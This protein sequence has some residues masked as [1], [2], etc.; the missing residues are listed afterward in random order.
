MTR[1]SSI[2]VGIAVLILQGCA[3]YMY[4]GELSAEDSDGNPRKVVIYWPMTDPLIGKRKAGPV[5]VLTECGIPIQFDQ[6]PEGVVFRGNPQ[7]DR[8]ADGDTPNV[9]EFECGRL[10]EVSNLVT[11][12]EGPLRFEIY[13][14]PVNDEFSAIRRTYIAAS[15]QPYEV[16]TTY[17]KSKSLMGKTMP[18]P[19]PPACNR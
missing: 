19:E 15:G 4:S 13:C 12:G 2:A 10:T 11:A 1:K 9:S 3:N 8:L 7:D 16:V 5:M 14:A 18:A 6:Q 17:E